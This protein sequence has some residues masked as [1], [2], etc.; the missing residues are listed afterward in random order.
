MVLSLLLAGRQ[1][2]SGIEL[3]VDDITVLDDV[4]PAELAEFSGGLKE[5]QIRI[6]I[7]KFK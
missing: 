3:E 1:S 5:K 7:L 2:A 6:K 4:I